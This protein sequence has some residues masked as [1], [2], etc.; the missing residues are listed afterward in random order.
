MRRVRLD[1]PRGPCLL[2][3]RPRP[4]ATRRLI[5]PPR[6]TPPAE[7]RAVDAATTARPAAAPARRPALPPVGGWHGPPARGVPSRSPPSGSTHP[8]HRFA[9]PLLS[10]LGGDHALAREISH[11][12]PH[13]RLPRALRAPA[14]ASACARATAPRDLITLP[15]HILQCFFLWLGPGQNIADTRVVT[16]RQVSCMNSSSPSETSSYQIRWRRPRSGSNST[17]W[18]TS[19]DD[20]KKPLREMP[21]PPALSPS[22]TGPAGRTSHAP[23]RPRRG[24]HEL[25]RS[26]GAS[27]RRPG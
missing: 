3:R 11:L 22:A 18:P 8:R 4:P 27:R 9:D 26:S 13:K 7:A 15:F 25:I 21:T 14:A 19:A 24:A 12:R 20:T 16:A 10:F 6:P 1:G 17:S 5:G 23:R 2:Q